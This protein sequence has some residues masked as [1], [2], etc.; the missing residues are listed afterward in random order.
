[1]CS[2]DLRKTILLLIFSSFITLCFSQVSLTIEN[3]DTGAGTFDI[4]MSNTAGCSYCEDS[5]YTKNS[6][7][8]SGYKDSCE[9]ESIGDTIWVAYDNSYTEAQCWNTCSGAITEGT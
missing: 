1:M 9:S 3:V 8:W 5:L 2:S 6:Q 4:Y 7:A